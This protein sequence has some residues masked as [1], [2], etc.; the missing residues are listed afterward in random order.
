MNDW[1]VN[2]ARTIGKSHQKANP[3]INFVLPPNLDHILGHSPG[4][5]ASGVF[6]DSGV[7]DVALI[8][9]LPISVP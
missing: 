6:R 2:S 3:L 1:I 5:V 8:S 9:I 7:L 4:R